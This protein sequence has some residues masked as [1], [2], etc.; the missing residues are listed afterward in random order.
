MSKYFSLLLAGLFLGSTGAQAQDLESVSSGA[1]ADLKKA[2]EE[3]TELRQRIEAERMPLARQVTDAEQ[4][5]ATRKTEFGKAQRFQENQLVELN[6]LKTEARNRSEEVKYVESLLSEYAR[7]FRSRL[8]FIEEPRYVELFGA[9]EKAGSNA[10]IS[11]AQRFE[12]RTA[13]LTRALQRSE[14]ALGGEVFEGKALDKQGRVQ[15]GKVALIGP[16]A[17]FASSSGEVGG[18]LQQELNKADPTIVSVNEKQDIGG[19]KLVTTGNGELSLDPTLGNAFKLSA[20][21]E[22]LYEKIAAGGLVMIPLLAL[23]AA[24]LVVA[25]VKWLQLSRIR[26]ATE[27]DLQKVLRH[28]EAGEQQKALAH[29]RSIPGPSGDLLATA[30]EHSDEKREYIE[31]ILYEKMLGARVKLER[32][33]AFLALSATTGPLMGLLG[34]VMGMIATFKLISSFGSGDPKLLASGISEALIATATGMAVAI[35]SLLLHAF[36]HRKAKGVIGSM[37]QTAVGFVNGIPE[38]A[39]HPFA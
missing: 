30:V 34:T 20:L 38:T 31:E 36:L 39:K 8:N 29:A 21:Q 7:A 10:D 35:P 33:I 1:G 22:T 23:G 9:V 11:P 3:L 25:L 6:A 14:A 16:V 4:K 37:E 19:R 18:L 5:L 26:L 28:I 32:G 17:T 2:L 13:L 12:E 24:A 27:A 15:Q